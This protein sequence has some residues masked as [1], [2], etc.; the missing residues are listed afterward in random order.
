[1]EHNN[2]S[3]INRRSA[4]Q[5]TLTAG[6]AAALPAAGAP[7]SAI[8]C[9]IDATQT[10]APITKYMYGALIEHI[11]GL[12]NNSLWAEM[13]DDRKF[14]YAVDFQPVPA[15]ARPGSRGAGRKWSPAGPASAVA[16]DRANPY[17]G[18]QSPV[19]TLTGTSPSGLQQGG[20]SLVKDK[21]YSGR[22]VVAGDP[23]A[24]ITAT[25]IWG[26]AGSDRQS[27]PIP[28]RRSWATVPLKF[29]SLA[30]TTDGRLEITGTGTGTF[31][32]G[33]ISL[34]P[35]DN[36]KGFRADTIAL[37]KDLD[38]GFYRLPGGNFVSG[39]D[40]RDAI[41]DHDKRPT[42]Y[43]PT[44]HVPQ[45][46]DVGTDELMTL[47]ALLGVEPYLCI[48]T[49]YGSPREGAEIVEYVNG[50][51]STAMGAMRAANGHPEPYKVKYW[52]VGNEMYGYWQMGYMAPEHY[53]IKHNMFAKAMR[54]VDPTITI[55]A[56]G[57]MPDE[58]TIDQCAY[59]IDPHTRQL[60][61][62]T[63]VDF[64]SPNDWTY[65]LLK[66][67]SGNFD[68]ISEH[69]YGDAHRFD[70]K[71]GKILSEDVPE[72]V[73]DTCRR[74][75]NRIRLKREYWE[76]YKKAFPALN[77]G[78]IKIS[79]DEWGFR[80]VRGLKQ[81]LGIAMTLHELFRNTDFITM[82]AFTMGMS[83]IDYNRTDCVYSNAGLLFKMYNS[84]FGTIPVTVTGNSPQ[85]APKWPVGGDQPQVNAGSPTWPLDMA[86]ALKKGGRTLTLAVVNATEARQQTSLELA[87][88]AHRPQGRMWRL[89]GSS[90]DAAN[91]VG[92]PPQVTVA[93][94]RFNANANHLSVAPYSVE[95]YEFTRA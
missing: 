36:V 23:G 73:L 68:I 75:P 78:K 39:H 21:S 42:T 1:M 90:L 45:P 72:S 76:R 58:M 31:R 19:V 65:R 20:I 24:Q 30:A 16:M 26:P 70:L 7:A 59:F 37:L 88:F 46:N 22:I 62:K 50:A 8:A 32:V 89:T 51:A 44:W 18:D 84:N 87:H 67:C 57:A 17:V 86:A 54:K 60:V 74:A 38:S 91:T 14:Y 82:A 27:V 33:A 71:V 47:C 29:K 35:D 69:C 53:M 55:I 66:D 15:G 5:G 80:N 41:G 43:D 10:G 64:A 49:G 94:E 25:L 92:K 85:P 13:L 81:T 2:N 63:E 40:W 3:G 95:I 48:D 79:V 12:I 93:E 4:L 77:E 6:L 61:G 9:R 28:A 52:N 56:V 83:W 34:M 11:G